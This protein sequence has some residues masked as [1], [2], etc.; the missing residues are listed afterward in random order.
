MVS[1]FHRT[2]V[3][4]TLPTLLGLP[5]AT[6]ATAHAQAVAVANA[7]TLPGDSGSQC[8][9]TS[10][11]GS[12]TIGHSFSPNGVVRG[13]TSSAQGV[14]ELP[15]LPGSLETWPVAIS[16]DGQ[17]A[18][19]FAF[20][21]NTD[22]AVRWTP[23]GI[24][25]LGRLPGAVGGSAALGISRDGSAVAGSSDSANGIRAM[26]WTENGGMQD[27]GILPAG[28]YSYGFALSANGKVVTGV[29]DSAMGELGFRWTQQQGMR[30]LLPLANGDST[31]GYA[32]SSQGNF[33]VGYS[34]TNA[35]R[36]NA[37]GIPQ[38]LGVLPGG[39]FSVA[40]AISGSGKLVGG[41]ADN[42]AGGFSATL[43]TP[44]LGTVDLNTFLPLVGIDTT[45]W[46]LEITTGISENGTTLV[47]VGTYQGSQVRG[48][49]LRM[50]LNGSSTNG[51]LRSR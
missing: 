20:F 39:F 28:S 13:F 14:V 43:W 51:W 21:S 2:L 15:S 19:G 34:G 48:W 18:A 41:G 5:I 37:A 38:D 4:L 44:T 25:E 6:S 12:I 10:S 29:A 47:G 42:A 49:I 30:P 3:R 7:G 40:Y 50:P 8:V 11:D 33:I 27:L 9:S 45:G 46:N 23:E 16:G 35:V 31:A 1:L 24:E 32:L 22:R 26:R 36:W 17:S